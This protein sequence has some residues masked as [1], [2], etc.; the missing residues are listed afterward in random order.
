MLRKFKSSDNKPKILLLEDDFDQMALLIDF[1]LSEIQTLMDAE[2][3]NDAQ[4]KQLANIHVMKVSNIDSLQKA[5]VKHKGVLL[6]LLDCNTPDA[7]GGASHD[8]LVPSSRGI[9]TGQHKA[10]D[11]IIKHLPETPITII[12][13]MDRFQR[14]VNKYY[15]NNDDLSINFV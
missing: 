1:T 8:Q 11:L 10:V 12:S 13:S 2:S 3:T 5:V 9:I 14:I 15:A 4:R 7:E 6:A